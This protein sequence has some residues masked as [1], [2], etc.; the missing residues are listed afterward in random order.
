LQPIKSENA[1]SHMKTHGGKIARNSVV[2]NGNEMKT[3]I[4]T[5]R[6]RSADSFVR[7]NKN[8]RRPDKSFRAPISCSATAEVLTACSVVSV[9]TEMLGHIK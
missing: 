5:Q 6:V 8:F 4:P 1:N 2:T 9:F 3:R 7:A